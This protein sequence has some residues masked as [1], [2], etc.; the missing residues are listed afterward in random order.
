[1][2][3]RIVS[4]S[5]LLL[6]VLAL[7]VVLASG[8]RQSS[9]ASPSTSAAGSSSKEAVKVDTAKMAEYF[10]GKTID[11]FIGYGPGGGYD[12]KGRIFVEFFSKYIPGNPQ[13]VI[14]NL[15]GGG[16]LQ[17][18]RQVLRAKPDGLTMVTIPSGL[19][20]NDLLGVKQ[21]GFSVDEPLKLGN[22]EAAANQFTVMLARTDAATTWQQM[23]DAGSKGKRFKYAAPAVGNTQAMSGEWLVAVG[24]PIEM[25]YGYGGSN[26]LLA[27]MDRKEVDVYNTDAPAE[28]REASFTRIQQAFPEWLK[29]NP[30]FVSPV[31]STRV[32]APQAWFEP[33]GWQ[34]PPNILDTVQASQAQKDGYKLAFQVRE[35]FD[36]LSLPKGVPADVY[37]TL[38]DAM[39]QAAEDPG[40]KAAMLQ[41]GF[42]GGY[43]TPE[44]MDQGLK[45]LQ[46]ASPETLSVVKRMYTGKS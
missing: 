27:A 37:Q 13:V 8:C 20:V 28:T 6:G 23:L 33:F 24:A 31:L 2:R 22:Y 30:R 46:G 43:R 14:Q 38:K 5:R 41:R 19:F 16:G 29:T 4:Q 17:A 42:E 12:I 45:A 34:V 10:K 21:E 39:K 7:L 11:L 40:Y 18:T 36:P 26:E 3:H 32:S 25:V 15:D 44:D 1:M 35:A 9:S